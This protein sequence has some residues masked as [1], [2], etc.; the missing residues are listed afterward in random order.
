MKRLLLTLTLTLTLFSYQFAR[1]AVEP[2]ADDPTKLF[3]RANSLYEKG[4]YTGALECYK[5]INS[6]G[7]DGG[8][9][10]YNI[11]NS[12]LKMGKI[13][14][15]ILYY[16]KAHRFMPGDGDLKSNLNYARSLLDRATVEPD[17]REQIVSFIVAPLG[18]FNLTA[19]TITFAITYCVFLGSIIVFV[20]LPGWRRRWLYVVAVS[21]IT[22][23][24]MG[25]QFWLKYSDEV[26]MEKG[27]VVKKEAPAKYEPIDKA[28]VFYK[29]KEGDK[30]TIL[31]TR[32]GWSYVKR[33]DGKCAWVEEG[34]VQK[35]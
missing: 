17:M 30:V 10:F 16:E 15:A 9:I 3:Y 4:D 31:K 35:I 14:Y 12:Y 6:M 8:N 26:L 28:T 20:A 11:G 25:L 19:V 32:A 27:I 24:F 1:A 5:A 33:V 29:L 22:F 21:G 2:G 23:I 13:G 18:D 7:I 34:A